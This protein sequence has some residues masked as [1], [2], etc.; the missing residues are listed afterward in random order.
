M[1]DS[2][3]VATLTV[4]GGGSFSGNITGS[5]TAL[6]V[7]G[8]SQT[9][10]LSG[11][12]TYG[13]QTTINSGDTLQAGST[14]A[15][16]S[17]SRITDNGT[18]NLNGNNETI[19]SLAGAG[20]VVLGAGTLTTG[21]DNTNTSFSGVIGI[22]GDTGGLTKIGSGTFTFSGVGYY[23]G[24]T[25]VSAGTLQLS[26]ATPANYAVPPANAVA[27]YSFNGNTNDAT[28]DGHNGTISGAGTTYV[29]GPP[30]LG[31]QALNLTGSQ[32]VTVPYSS[33]FGLNSYTVSAWVDMDS[34]FASYVNG[35]LGT[36]FG[37]PDETFD[38]K[39]QSTGIHGD[40]GTG[41]SW[42]NTSVDIPNAQGGQLTAGT[43]AMVT[44][45]VDNTNNLFRLY[46]DGVLLN[47]IAYTGT[48]LFMQPG[49]TLEIGDSNGG[50][51]MH[52]AI[53]DVFIY[54]RALS[55]GEI[56]S[57]FSPSY[58]VLPSATNVSVAGG[59]SLDLNGVPQTIGSL[60]GSGTVT[61]SSATVGTLTVTGGG[62]FSGNITGASTALTVGG[63]S[64]TLVL[65]GDNT[66]GG[67]TTINSGDTLQAGSATALSPNS[68]VSDSGTLNL[69]NFSNTI[70]SL[71]GGGNVTL[72]SGT[73]TLDTTS[74]TSYSGVISGSGGLTV[75]G[76]G[77]QALT[78]ANTYTGSTQ[79]N[80]TATVITDSNTALG[81]N[82]NVTVAAGAALEFQAGLLG[83]YYN[84]YPTF[85]NSANFT[86]LNA[87]NFSLAGLTPYLTELSATTSV[88]NSFDFSDDNGN[89]VSAFP[90]P[91]NT[92]GPS[93][94]GDF[95]AV[96]TGQ[97]DAQTAGTYTFDT[98]SDDGSMLFIDGNVVVNNNY[99][100]GVTVRSG[101]VSLTQGLHSIV[102]A[103]YE[104][105]GDF[106]LYADVTPPGGASE[107]IPN[108]LLNPATSLQ[109][110]SLAGAGSVNLGTGTL[111]TG[112]SLSTTFSG[113]IGGSG[114]LD[115]QGTGTFTLGGANT[116]TGPTLISAGA[117]VDTTNNTALGN[118][119]VTVASGATLN[120]ESPTSGVGLLG[121]YYNVYPNLPNPSNFVS[122][123]ALN[124][125]LAG[126]TPDLTELS[127]TTSRANSLDFGDD[128]GADVSA[129]PA[130]YNTNGPNGHGYFEAVYTGTFNAPTAGT[131]TFDTD[132][133]DGSM[134]FIDGNVVVN[135]NAFQGLTEQSGTVSL[136]QGPHSIV[137]AYY[138]GGGAFG[139]YAGVTLPG[140]TSED[141]P[142]S[143]L[144]PNANF[145]S[146]GSLAGTGSVNVSGSTLAVG[147]D[148]ASS[149]FGGVL[150]GATGLVKQGSG[151]FTLSSAITYSGATTIGAGT[152]QLGVPNAIPST[153][154]VTDDGTLDLDG[155]SATIGALSSS[156]TVT[157]SVAGAV[158]LTV[159]SDNDSGAF[160]GVIQ[161]G[162]GTMALIKN[163]AGVETLSGAVTYTGATTVNAGQ[164]L[165][166]NGY[167]YNS[168]TTVNSGA[169]LAWSGNGDM[170][171]GNTGDTILLNNGSTLENLNPASWTVINGV[172][173]V[174]SGADV[175]I[176]QT[177]NATAASGEG[178]Y[179]DGGLQGTGTVTINAANA[180]SGVNFRNSNTTFSGTMIVNG[181]ASATPFAG[182]GIGVGG[183]T[184][185]LQNA[186]IQLN[187]TM[188]L[189]NVGIGWANGAYGAFTM[190]ALS[191]SGVAV[192][193]YTGT[194]GFTTLT[195][196][197]SN[198][199]GVFSGI[200]ADG[201]GDM[202]HVVQTG[203][204]TE[205]LSGANTYSG[206]TTVAAGTLQLGSA[207]ALGS[208]VGGVAVDS[209]AVLDLDGQTLGNYTLTANGTGA[210]QG[211]VTNSSTAAASFSGNF[212]Y[213]VYT[214]GGT[215]NITFSG[216]VGTSSSGNDT[217]TKVAGDTLILSGTADNYGLGVIADSGIVVL[218]KNPSTTN[219]N[220]HAI[221]GNG[222]TIAGA[223]V[224]LGGTG[225]AQIY[226]G[227]NVTI[228]S[229]TF[230]LE[231][232]SQSIYSLNGSGGTVLDSGALATL[233]VTG[234][235]SFGGN[236]AGANTALTVAG[237]TLALSGADT[238]SGATIISGGTLQTASA[239]ALPSGTNVTANGT[240][241]LD[242]SSF[243]VGALNG[244]GA[245]I[246]SGTAA[247]LTVTG[248]GAFSGS[249]TGANTAL[250]VAGAGQT[251]TLSGY[252]N[253]SGATTVNAGQLVLFNAYSY[254]SPT[255]VNS[256][257]ILT[258][259][260][261]TDMDD[262]ST[263][264]TITLNNGATLQN[265]NPV[266]WTV[267][268][269]V[270]TVAA[271]ASVT[272]NQTS[273]AT[274][275]SGEGFYLDGGLQGTGTVTINAANAG[276]GVNFR[277]NN[278]T[279]S[280]TM[281][282]NGIASATP[283]AG[284]GIG[285]G[286][287]TTGLQNADIQL[288][289]TMELL[290]V[291]IGWANSWGVNFAMGALSG[292]GVMVGNSSGDSFTTVTLGNTND[293]GVFS[294]VIA[295]GSGDALSF[296][297]T[298]TGTETLSGDNT[299]TGSTTI[300]GGTLQVR[301]ADAL[302]TNTAVTLA[303]VAGAALNLNGFNVT[304][305]SLAGG[306]AVG[307]NV[308]LG[309]G[310]L[311]TGGN[312][313]NTT[314]S[315]VISGTGGLT[316]QG[317]G[318]FTLGAASTY[319]GATTVNGTLNLGGIS[320]TI[321]ALYGSGTVTN[322]MTSVYRIDNG[323]VASYF[324]NSFT[325][326]AEDNWLGNVFTAAAGA[327]QLTSV[328]FL[329]GETINASNLP[330]PYVTAAL[331]T[332]APA[333]V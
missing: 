223:A 322:L 117:T 5:T 309:S 46:I 50:E 103:Y 290:N 66:D 111:T 195:L 221:G 251:L 188:E 177:S 153:S 144:N 245:V 49:Q 133:D 329:A 331:Y 107:R 113:A 84:L 326:E 231:G 316:V 171:D 250:T 272:I 170:D 78:G 72:G 241:D 114:G 324:N 32:A 202:V 277:N 270:V 263:G 279:F 330:S 65:S 149:T 48:P 118:S 126:L 227:D 137:I 320:D 284:S 219:P 100:Q 293:G 26:N 19:G 261:N 323:V 42:I 255:T 102:I 35:I 318:I 313:T 76:S 220:V 304:I 224:Q 39:V 147:G 44:Y 173:T 116:F 299:Y 187:G 36:R 205:T 125:S 244:S 92:N 201:T 328:S 68:S 289:G 161:N 73:L 150:S 228:T 63:T 31:A 23:T 259:T 193:N 1:I 148:N 300:D 181:I 60:N 230:D 52:G 285:V 131:Y 294:G 232:Q 25:T 18:L 162:A 192:G 94:Q 74:Y 109:I 194:G 43:W 98:G 110:G 291:G 47:T 29:Q 156:G 157:T 207:T 28:G 38:L 164:L 256:G 101:T 307:G 58:T 54:G 190:G 203:T 308:T 122:L 243:S 212:N 70:G 271:G 127:A 296:I 268:N 90:A 45:V 226:Q 16:S 93:G 235:G 197:H 204:G 165:L 237:G 276:S 298:G 61:D 239:T 180:G 51:Y 319:T 6:T 286:G 246:D 77:T 196:G 191:G 206:G 327:T 81:N 139:L 260:G 62:S 124:S 91:F 208:T 266:S 140:G 34:G 75:E 301:S 242:G 312:N 314:Y 163:G 253:Y 166:F 123:A 168:P 213:G 108:S 229:G 332:G 15:L 9:L 269:G 53:A 11:D 145:P 142:N 56:S 86:S 146:I 249:I 130:P 247:I 169:T 119:D 179:P 265:L 185:G 13:G 167:S 104:G 305:G 184:T 311:T 217:L 172:V 282:V 252:V 198:D 85:P 281:I 178:F 87:L 30:Q 209:G 21:A 254:D 59:A 41:S 283:F 210:G 258:W 175:T 71:A 129:F 315:G 7:G 278:T 159:G 135:N 317:T 297:K 186:D 22:S 97:F 112:D 106:G 138:Q 83:Q 222:L 280:G 151:T 295:N 121:Q 64:Q 89:D 10:V 176:N 238:Y 273:N 233:T 200:I 264:D 257:A 82:S 136:T 152:L 240:L 79:I 132:S 267:L 288:N 69:N 215:G 216:Q 160:S 115:I 57:L 17:A 310:T 214:V 262:G 303:N 211:A 174:A 218:A 33:A 287:D 88:N 95:E 225:G 234:G 20:T 2:G 274:A 275:A 248:G 292:S 182:S 199:S 302:P 189:N 27:E 99:I 154:D 158:T 96:Y 14:T 120:V 67:Q 155:R 12:N 141:I 134:L 321:G 236:I 40:A 55:Q 37:G 183:D 80:N 128:D 333:R 306:G 325:T 8:T 4:T 3:A 24:S 105:G 143:L